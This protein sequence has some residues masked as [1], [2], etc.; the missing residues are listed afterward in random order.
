MRHHSLRLLAAT[1][2]ML[3]V[4]TGCG[5][6]PTGTVKSIKSVKNLQLDQTQNGTAGTSVANGQPADQQ[7]FLQKLMADLNAAHAKTNSISFDLKGQ[8]VNLKTGKA[9]SNQVKFVFEKPNKTSVK[10]IESTESG[11]AGTKLVWTGGAK[12]AVHTQLLGFW[13]NTDVDIH[14]S[15]CTDQRGYFIDQTSIAATM[16]TLLDPRNQVRSVNLAT[17]KGVPVAQLDIVSPRRLE[18]I[19]HE[20]FTIDGYKKLPVAREM[21]DQNNRLVYGLTM[22]NVVMNGK[23]SSST[24]TL[25]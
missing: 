23:L 19:A 14:D 7:A 6:S 4:L 10:I 20:V 9:G 8:F 3:G 1:L 18:G 24:F 15:R 25:Q 13:L 22:E 2:T 5:S 16:E 21:Y 11:M 12:L 17:L